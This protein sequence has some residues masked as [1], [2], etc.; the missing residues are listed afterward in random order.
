MAVRT[1]QP[2]RV[3]FHRPVDVWEKPYL[4]ECYD[5]DFARQV[6]DLARQTFPDEA[7]TL[8]WGARVIRKWPAD[9]V[10]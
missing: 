8:A 9:L 10:I 4:A 5:V 7:I 3:A 6:F 2:Y 1:P